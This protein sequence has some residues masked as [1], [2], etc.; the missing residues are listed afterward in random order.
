MRSNK[1]GKDAIIWNQE[2]ISTCALFL[3]V[4]PESTPAAAKGEEGKNTSLSLPP[5][6]VL[7]LSLSLGF[8]SIDSD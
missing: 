1:N 5:S 7:S 8:L 2:R 3:V 6:L 4:C